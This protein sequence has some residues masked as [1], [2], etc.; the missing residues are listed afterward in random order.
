MW[1]DKTVPLSVVAG[2]GTTEGSDAGTAA[3]PVT[4]HPAGEMMLG[5]RGRVGARARALAGFSLAVGLS[6]V[7]AVS[8]GDT[9]IHPPLS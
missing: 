2:A 3:A 8:I 9:T 4:D 5:R 7:V 1:C 6:T